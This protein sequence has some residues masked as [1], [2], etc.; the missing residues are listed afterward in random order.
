TLLVGEPDACLA[1]ALVQLV[2]DGSLRSGLLPRGHTLDHVLQGFDPGTV[3]VHFRH[4][5]PLPTS[6]ADHAHFMQRDAIGRASSRAAGI[7]S[8]Q[9]RHTPYVP[10]ATR[11]KAASI[12]SRWRRVT[13]TKVSICD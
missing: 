10:S 1:Q 6:S 4:G 13:W 9:P 7:R 2:V 11:P 3:L 12:S 8:P 5:C